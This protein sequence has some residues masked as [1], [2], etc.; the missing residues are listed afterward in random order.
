ML[1]VVVVN[2]RKCKSRDESA[3]AFTAS[4]VI[5]VI[6]V[7]KFCCCL[8]RTVWRGNNRSEGRGKCIREG[9][10]DEEG[11]MER[12]SEGRASRGVEGR[13]VEGRRVEE[14]RVEERIVVERIVEE[15]RGNI[16]K[17]GEWM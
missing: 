2:I 1:F 11:V 14:R 7:S 12:E 4:L 6:M 10:D 8:F 17:G 9:R 13:R 3:C 5:F 15:R 16:S